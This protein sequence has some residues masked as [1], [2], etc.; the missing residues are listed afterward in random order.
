MQEKA[1]FIF[2]VE[3]RA[4]FCKE[5]DEPIHSANSLAANHQ[6]FLAT[7]IRVA[8]SSSCKKDAPNAQLEPQ[9]PKPN[10]QQITVKTPSQQLSGITSPSWAV[11]DLLG[12]SDY[13]SSEKKEQLELG[14]LEWLK[15]IGLFGEHEVPE[16][17]VA[18]QPSHA[19]MNKS[20]KFYMP[21]KKARIDV[22]DDDEFFT[23][24]DLG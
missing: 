9:P 7:G 4:L 18:P 19:S 22:P 3:D 20:A 17:S 23:V 14:E 10:S 1:A 15:D 21:H 24:P 2:C 16:L 6:R 12:F 8:L 13:E 11:D 5:C